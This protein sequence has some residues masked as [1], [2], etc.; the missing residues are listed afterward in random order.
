MKSQRSTR[1]TAPVPGWMTLLAAAV[2]QQAL[3]DAS[4]PTLPL[5]ARLDAKQFLAGNADY[6]LWGRIAEGRVNGHQRPAHPRRFGAA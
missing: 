3:V 5:A 2:V 4:D 1:A 6:R